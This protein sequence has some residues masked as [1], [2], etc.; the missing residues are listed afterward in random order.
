MRA[1]FAASLLSIAMIICLTGFVVSLLLPWAALNVQAIR[2]PVKVDVQLE[3]G[4]F[5][6]MSDVCREYK[7][8]M[9]ADK[10]QSVEI[11]Q[12]SA[13]DFPIKAPRVDKKAIQES[14]EPFRGGSIGAL[15]FMG[16]GC[17]ILLMNLVYVIYSL[18]LGVS[19]DV[20][21]GSAFFLCLT[22]I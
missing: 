5:H 21:S 12:Q 22:I 11:V 17:S 4:L 16:I 8:L 10:Q 20:L 2:S 7:Q 15:T 9:D 1:S 14:L 3:I 6:C 13:W 19:D 18:R